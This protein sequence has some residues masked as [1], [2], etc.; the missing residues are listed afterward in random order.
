M[1][2]R[3]QELQSKVELLEEAGLDLCQAVDLASGF[4]DFQRGLGDALDSGLILDEA[5][6]R[7]GR[8]ISFQGMAIYLVNEEDSD[9]YFAF[10][11]RAGL[12]K[13]FNQEVD[14]LIERGIFNSA[15]RRK[16]K[17]SSLSLNGHEHVV[18]Q[19]L[20]TTSRIRGMFAGIIR[21]NISRVPDVIWSLQTIILSL[22]AHALESTELY[23]I[24]K[25]A[26]HSLK[27]AVVEGTAKSV[28]HLAPDFP[29]QLPGRDMIIK[30][31]GRDIS[32]SRE[33][34]HPK[35]VAFMIIHLDMPGEVKRNLDDEALHNFLLQAG[36]RLR[37]L[38]P[39]NDSAAILGDDELGAV[40]TG[41]EAGER[42][43][44]TA[45][46]ILETMSEPFEING[47]HL[48]LDVSIGIAVYPDHGKNLGQ[49]LSNAD[50]AMYASRRSK[51]G[52][53]FYDPNL[54]STGISHV[55]LRAELKKSLDQ[56]QL[57]FYFQPELTLFPEGVSGV[58]AFPRWIHPVR[59]IIPGREF[60][61]LA[62]HGG[63][64]R[65]LTSRLIF[66]AA[67]QVREWQ[68][69]GAALKIGF[70]VPVTVFQEGRLPGMLREAID[71][72]RIDPHFLGIELPESAFGNASRK[73]L[74][75]VYAIHELGV[76]MC[77][78][79][80]GTGCSSLAGLKDL[81]VQMLKIDPSLVR[82]MDQDPGDAG[83][84]SSIISLGHNLGLR[85]GAKGV[86]SRQVQES[87]KDLGC[88]VAQGAHIMSISPPRD[89]I[90][91]LM[92]GNWI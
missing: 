23:A 35:Q 81:P 63:F 87:L 26:D 20:S 44:K 66:L 67:A 29:I 64:I 7:I 83:I 82:N 49:I 92:Q 3:I 33:G 52:L 36:H 73:A 11:D 58:E 25:D 43:R 79:D 9:F 14:R 6:S 12:E 2:D 61:P 39:E 54:V 48:V 80:F 78:D 13:R 50:L 53:I 62:E 70:N 59:G 75:S 86:R 45:A 56:D 40:I 90:R 15:I 91:W 34:L 85:V 57:T 27:K 8:L 17:I 4:M 47:Q 65:E 74:N 31:L 84:V 72:H 28:L 77:I 69:M 1:N 71:K 10:T 76:S 18:L 89:V 55:S 41:S 16:K 88:D 68:K 51:T 5:C 32:L 21:G 38:V 46:G 24:L 60:M 37:A 19:V 22:T 30:K 42:A